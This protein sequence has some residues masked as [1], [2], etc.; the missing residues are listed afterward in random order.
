M[1]TAVL[2]LMNRLVCMLL[3]ATLHVSFQIDVE[4]NEKL[5]VGVLKFGT[6]NWQLRIVKDRG[7]DQAAGIDLKI[8]PLASKNATSVALQAGSADMI[9]TDWI[10]ALRQRAEG[11]DFVFVP[12]TRTLGALVLAKGV[13][14]DGLAGLEGKR[15]GIAGGPLD[16]SWLVLQASAL[17]HLDL[18]LAASVVPVFG[19]P[20]LL[21]E[22]LRNGGVDAVLTFWPYAA[23]LKAEGFHTAVR[24]ETV[25]AG[26]GI[27][28][29]PPLVGYV[30][31]QRLADRAPQVVRGFIA[32]IAGANALLAADDSA[33]DTIR[34]LMKAADDEEFEALRAGYRGGIP[35]PNGYG[36]IAGA[37]QLFQIMKEIGGQKLLGRAKSFDMKLFWQP[38]GA[39]A[40]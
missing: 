11:E 5:T 23:R 34:P 40:Q 36:D 18:N 2:K 13:S 30:F 33:W 3:C 21:S 32:A 12:Y 17:R 26:L 35:D 14:I 7:L 1:P 31:R 22:Q 37:E 9:V 20:P 4:A 24:V 16:K 15:V 38:D 19:A 25:L 10:W 8:L 6:V 28:R 29:A 27:D 39:P